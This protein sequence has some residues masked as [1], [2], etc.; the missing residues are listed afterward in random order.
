[1]LEL[2]CWSRETSRAREVL[3]YTS[4]TTHVAIIITLC[5]MYPQGQGYRKFRAPSRVPTV[6]I[7]LL[8][9][10]SQFSPQD[11]GFSGC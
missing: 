6:Y 5:Q 8:E 2:F 1:M 11:D 3:S 7:S 10:Y 4:I 9:G